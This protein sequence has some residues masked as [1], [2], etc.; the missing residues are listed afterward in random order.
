ML[1]CASVFLGLASEGR[2]RQGK[3]KLVAQTA[4]GE[5]TEI[6]AEIAAVE[7]KPAL[8]LDFPNWT[9]DLYKRGLESLGVHGAV[10]KRLQTAATQSKGAIVVCGPPGSGKTTTLYA[11]SGLID[12]FTTDVIA[13]EKDPEVELESIRHWSL[14]ADKS[15]AEGF[16]EL[17]REGPNVVMWGEI[18]EAEQAPHL[19]R[20]A[21]DE[22]LVLT[23]IRA[24]D[25]AGA[26]IGLS[27]M[28]GD[29]KLVSGAVSCV[30]SQRLVRR[31]CVSCREQVEP[32]PAL[33]AKLKLDPA[34]PGQWYRPVGCRACL[35]CGFHGQI[36]I[37]EMLIITEPV[38]K[39]LA[40]G[41]TSPSAIRKA[42]G[43]GALRSMYQDGLTKVTAGITT[44]EEIRRVLAQPVGRTA[45]KAGEKSQ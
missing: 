9:A 24:A 26:L 21:S 14:P 33:V 4:G 18:T 19:M 27:K 16:A 36:G 3:G 8:V 32:N 7:G 35:S 40:A 1:A 13:V 28:A 17:L 44:L 43:E 23:T 38:A 20:F 6:S 39:A 10:L 37:Y 29:A 5:S 45:K 34:A 31:L 12:I 25:A 41:N 30:I 22:G 11:I 2:V 42:A 15:L